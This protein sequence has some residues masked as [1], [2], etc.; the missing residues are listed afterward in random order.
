M[1]VLVLGGT[2]FIGPRVMRL[3]CKMSLSPDVCVHQTQ[4]MFS[5]VGSWSLVFA[6]W[7]PALSTISVAMAGITKMPLVIFLA[8]DVSGTLIFVGLAA[9]TGRIFQDEVNHILLMLGDVG[10]VG[11]ALVLAILV[12]Y[13]LARWWRRRLF[14]RRLSAN[15]I[16]VDELRRSI[17]E[18]RKPLILDVRPKEFRAQDGIIPGAVA[19]T[20]D[21]IEAVVLNYPHDSQIVVYCACP[22]EA[23]AALAAKR[24]QRAGFKM[25]RPLLGGVDAWVQ[26]GQPL[27]RPPETWTA[28]RS[29]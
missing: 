21:N 26:A 3:L 29:T 6:K 24:L 4:N 12:L 23:S 27:E 18:G 9:L 13:L 15:R 11:A 1:K 14:I 17:D 16:T 25:V 8:F 5:K 7:L 2:G 28:K 10:K 20:A 19:A 22:N